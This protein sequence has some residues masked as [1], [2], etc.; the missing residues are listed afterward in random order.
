MTVASAFLV[1]SSPL[2]YFKADNPPWSPLAD[3]MADVA[4]VS[5]RLIP[6]Y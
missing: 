6:M 4:N 2:P 3:A 5:Q 1:P